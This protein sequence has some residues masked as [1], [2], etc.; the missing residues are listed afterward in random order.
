MK[1]KFKIIQIVVIFLCFA[2]ISENVFSQER[3]KEI[4]V[5]TSTFDNFKI[6]YKFGDESRLFRITTSYLSFQHEKLSIPDDYRNKIGVE[7]AAGME[8]PKQLNDKLDFICGFELGGAYNKIIDV[9]NE[10][11]T[12]RGSGILGLSYS[13]NKVLKFGFEINPG[14]YYSMDKDGGSSDDRFGI[15]LNNSFAEINLGFVF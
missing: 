9:E 1:T 2:G 15:S 6:R 8:F 12:V 7:L 14:I 5:A 10:Y 3:K 13:V 4:S 11:Y